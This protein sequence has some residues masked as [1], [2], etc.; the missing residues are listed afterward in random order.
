MHHSNSGTI[1]VPEHTPALLIG[2]G[3]EV[4]ARP[5]LDFEANTKLDKLEEAG[6]VVLPPGE[7]F[8]PDGWT[9]F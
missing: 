3:E 9:G 2:D 4:I 7:L 1:V 6:H 8:S 5:P